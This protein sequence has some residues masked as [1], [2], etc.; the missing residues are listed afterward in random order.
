MKAEKVGQI[1]T[2]GYIISVKIEEQPIKKYQI[3]RLLFIHNEIKSGRHPTSV[4]LAAEYEVS[5]KTIR[6]DIEYLKDMLGAPVI[7]SR[8]HG[9]YIYTEPGF[10][11]PSFMLTEGDVFALAVGQVVLENYRESPFYDRLKDVFDRIV[12]SLPESGEISGADVK[13][14]ISTTHIPQV[15]IDPEIFQ[16]VYKAV[17]GHTR[18]S[19]DYRAPAYK[20]FVH[21]GCDPYR[22]VNHRGNWYV[23]G[24]EQPSGMVKIW[25]LN[26]MKNPRAEKD[27]FSIPADFNLDECIDQELGIFVTR[28][29]KKV[30][31]RFSAETAGIIKER[32]WHRDQELK[33]LEDGGV[34]LSFTTNQLEETLFWVFTWGSNAVIE[35]PPELVKWA[36]E[37]VEEMRENY[38]R[39]ENIKNMG[40]SQKSNQ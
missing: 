37:E 5:D 10:D 20:D 12:Q 9:G 40:W 16:R 33:D 27:T 31:I 6:R 28:E 29:R 23:I 18:L 2:R 8:K 26:R 21:R 38:R 34:R 3:P 7:Y 24:A 13:G 11:V 15:I 36:R 39:S 32:T 1:I 30:T 25:A 4:Q 19:F 35:E 17:S 14:I 22:I